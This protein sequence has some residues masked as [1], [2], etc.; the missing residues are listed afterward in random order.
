M[1][2]H[3]LDNPIQRAF[4]REAYSFILPHPSNDK[5]EMMWK[6]WWKENYDT[7]HAKLLKKYYLNEKHQEWSIYDWNVDMYDWWEKTE[8]YLVE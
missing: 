8:K 3:N 1:T 4:Y 6:L 2:Y 5:I 7:N